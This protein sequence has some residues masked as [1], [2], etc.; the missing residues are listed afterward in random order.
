MEGKLN[1]IF[2]AS[3]ERKRKQD[4]FQ[5]AFSVLRITP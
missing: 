2:E 1:K 4:E 5:E 3:K